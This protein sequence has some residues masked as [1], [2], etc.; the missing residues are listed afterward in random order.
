MALSVPFHFAASWG[1]FHRSSPTGGE[2]KG[3]P[4]KNRIPAL[5][6]GL[7]CSFPEAIETVE[8][9]LVAASRAVSVMRQEN[10]L[11]IDR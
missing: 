7:P 10:T 11:M 3:M 2:A 6:L 1:D 8:L 4:R 9:I 5:F